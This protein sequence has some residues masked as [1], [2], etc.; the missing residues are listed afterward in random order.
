MPP[1]PNRMPQQK[2]TSVHRNITTITTVKVVW[3]KRHRSAHND[4]RRSTLQLPCR[5]IRQ[6]AACVAKLVLGCTLDPI[7]EEGEVVANQQWYHSK[8]RRWFP[9]IVTIALSVTIRPQ[10]AIE[11]LRRSNQ[12]GHFW[13]KIWGGCKPNLN[14]VWKRYRDVICKRNA[15]DIV[16]LFST[17]HKR[18]RHCQTGH[19]MV[20]SIPF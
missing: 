18:D 4:L 3:Y 1:P 19:G 7:L 10:F 11:C 8:E 20:T 12:Q 5:Y 2:Q 6:V 13:G 16:C 15:V 17:V 9:A 14:A